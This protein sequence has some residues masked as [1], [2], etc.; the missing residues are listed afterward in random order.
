MNNDLKNIRLRTWEKFYPGCSE[1]FQEIFGTDSPSISAIGEWKTSWYQTTPYRFNI[2]NRPV[3]DITVEGK[4]RQEV[5]A[6]A[7]YVGIHPYFWDFWV[8]REEI[9]TSDV[10]SG[11]N[12]NAGYILLVRPTVSFF[13]EEHHVMFKLAWR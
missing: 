8:D 3:Q 10:A 4:L 11:D 6:T 1:D 13:K 12:I 5:E 9:T 7:K 2:S